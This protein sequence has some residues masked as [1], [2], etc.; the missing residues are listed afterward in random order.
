M[1]ATKRGAVRLTKDTYPTPLWCL[2][3]LIPYLDKGLTYWEPA[4]GDGRLVR[5]LRRNG[6]RADG[7]DI[8]L[9]RGKDF[10][11]DSTR[12]EAVLANPPYSLAFEFA[13]HSIEHAEQTHLLLRLGFLASEE[14]REWFRSNEPSSLFI[15][16]KRPSFVISCLCAC[17][18]HEYRRHEDPRLWRCPRC[19]RSLKP[20]KN[21]SADY[22]WYAWGGKR[23]GIV[24]L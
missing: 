17:G 20:T 12:R 15:L 13:R 3:A 1:S 19:D 11:K 18:F 23:R 4:K 9:A 22:A 10:L 14:R 21:D 2:E 7:T 5:C 24:H 8:A 16:S 6:F